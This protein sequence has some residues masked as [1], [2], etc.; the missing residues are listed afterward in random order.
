MPL[1]KRLDWLGQIAGFGLGSVIAMAAV[2]LAQWLFPLVDFMVD[3][4]IIAILVLVVAA[5]LSSL[6]LR[7]VP[8]P[9]RR[10]NAVI[11]L[12]VA[13]VGFAFLRLL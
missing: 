8:Q 13:L 1:T 10:R 12:S 2:R 9:R 6:Y 3:G 7:S 5:Y 11:M 4:G